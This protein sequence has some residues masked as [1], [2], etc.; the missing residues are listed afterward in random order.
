MVPILATAVVAIVAMLACSYVALPFGWTVNFPLFGGEP[1]PRVE[2]GQRLRVPAGFG[3]G[4]YATGVDNARMLLFT[5]A[6]DLL[7]SSPRTGS[8]LLL[9]RDA[10]GDGHADGQ[11]VL[12]AGL[13]RPHGLAL[14][15]GWLYVAESDAI[16][17]VRFDPATRTVSGP[18][19]TV[20]SG[21]PG[22]GNHWTRTIAFGPDGHL[23]VSI[24]SSCNV[25]I[26]DD[27]RRAAIV[28]Y[29]ADGKG[30][31]LY[32][33]GLRNAVGFAWQP[34]TGA[35]Y[36]TDNGRDLLGD[37]FPPDEL[38]R[39][40]PAGF[41]GWPFA[42]GN[43]VPDPDFGRGHEEDV[44]R[45]IPP[46]HAFGAHTAS[47]GIAFYDH[48]GAG[49]FPGEY[50]GAAFVAQHGSWNR[51]KKIGYQVV[52]LFF[53]PDRTIRE[54]PFL[55]GLLAGETVYGRPVGVAVGPDGALYVSDDFTGSIYRI[56]YGASAAAAT[57]S[58]PA[59]P[60]AAA[61]PLAGISAAE[62]NAAVER[63][64]ALWEKNDCARCH[65]A[66][67]AASGTPRAG[68]PPRETA[69]VVRPLAGLAAKYRVDSLMSFLRAPQPPMPAFPL[70]DADRRD[71]AVY[72]L[73]THP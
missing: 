73:A 54:Q 60:A 61:D 4:Q 10:N 48:T 6:G 21:L 8:V 64:R 1:I 28:R 63:G 72:L 42:N 32:A 56:A 58:P 30:E 69:D 7:V 47:L 25:C 51:S 27:P 33:T 18:R 34:S 57:A 20:V 35:L 65:V 66:G 17:R 38:N 9:E 49:A 15:D 52:A 36:A 71:L 67:A 26:E 46:A 19:E 23:Y 37:D 70:T 44:A 31:E 16:L 41:Y 45:S 53:G 55:T 13:D 5:P 24:G 2:V 11:N 14:R 12:I 68:E 39:I 59:A 29:T 43:R 62:R 22:G 3:V 40:A 50:Q